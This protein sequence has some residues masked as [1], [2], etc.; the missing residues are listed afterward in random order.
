MDVRNRRIIIDFLQSFVHKG[1]EESPVSK[2]KRLGWGRF[3]RVTEKIQSYGEIIKRKLCWIIFQPVLKVPGLY[4]DVNWRG[5]LGNGL[6]NQSLD[7][8]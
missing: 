6:K 5:H 2:I 8:G 3:R 7:V 1:F 4:N